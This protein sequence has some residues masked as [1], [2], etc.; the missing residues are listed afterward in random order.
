MRASPTLSATAR[1]TEEE[2]VSSRASP[3]RSAFQS[4]SVDPSTSRE[5]GSVGF[6]PY[7]G[8][9]KCQFDRLDSWET[10]AS[11]ADIASWREKYCE[12]SISP[13]RI[14]ATI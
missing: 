9:L 2:G 10:A 1:G 13:T 6:L 14:S 12:V 5:L 4:P 7:V 11:I 3:R 8:A